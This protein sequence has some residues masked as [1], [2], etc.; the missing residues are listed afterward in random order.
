[1][2]EY[3][4]RSKVKN[5]NSPAFV[6]R[7]MMWAKGTNELYGII[8]GILIDGVVSDKEAEFLKEWIL[9]RP[10]VIGDP[11]VARLAD[12]LVR[13]CDDGVVT[14][15]ESDELKE[16]FNAYLGKP[17]EGEPT[18]LP[19]D[20][21]PPDVRVEGSIFCFTGTFIS[22]TRRWCEE[23]TVKRGGQFTDQARPGIDYLVIG[24]KVSRGWVNQSYGRKIETIVGYRDSVLQ[25]PTVQFKR[26]V[27][28]IVVEDHW[29]RFL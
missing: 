12:R 6:Q 14:E 27:P 7:A 3:V 4:L 19:L 17:D 21:P 10:D 15:A 29:L 1:M 20:D 9:S 11:L 25:E 18:E 22:G 16:I 28:K 23:E 2:K 24:S 26:T 5:D 13:V 8:R